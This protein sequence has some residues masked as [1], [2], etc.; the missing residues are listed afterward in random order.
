MKTKGAALPVLGNPVPWRRIEDPD[1]VDSIR[2]LD[3]RAYDRC[4]HL[5][6][7]NGWRG[8]TCNQ[9]TA[10]Q[11]PTAYE[12]K[13]DMMGALALLEETQLLPTLAHEP[14][15]LDESEERDDGDDEQPDAERELAAF[16][17]N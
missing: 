11:D 5:A 1:D 16:H 14:V 10:Y 13:R 2:R 9:C 8:F 4:L 7:E 6:G 3:C 15:F 17:R 12:R